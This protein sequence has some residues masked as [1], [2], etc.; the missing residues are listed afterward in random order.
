MEVVMALPLRVLIVEDNERDAALLLRELKRGGYDPVSERVETS[1]TMNAE[2]ERRT[3]DLVVSDFAMPQFSANAALEE[4][5]KS[6][7]DLPF[8]IV[9]G[10]V[11]EETAVEAMRAGAHDFMPKG[12]FTRLLPA[13]AR[14]LR[15]AELRAKHRVIEQ[16]LRQ[17]QKMEAIGQLTGGI[18]HDFNNLLAVIVGNL[19]LL[20]EIDGVNAARAELIDAALNSALRGAELTKRLLAFA[21]QQPLSAQV[22]DLNDCLPDMIAILQRTIGESIQIKTGLATDLWLARVDPAQLE[23]ALLNLAIN[24]R[25]AMPD[26]G[27]LLIETANTPLDADYAASHA[28][29]T[30]GDYVSLAVMD[31]GTG[32]PPDI[33]ERVIEPFFTT[34]EHGKG[35]GLGLSM[36]YGFAKQSGGHLSINS[37]IGVGTTMSLYFPR[38]TPDGISA[39]VKSASPTAPCGNERILVVEDNASVRNAAV[40]ILRSLGYDVEHAESARAALASLE[41]KSFDVLFTDVVMPEMNGVALA[42]EV[43]QCYPELAILFTSGFSSKLSPAELQK[44]GSNFVAKPY[45]K[46]D[47]A[48]AVRAAL[49]KFVSATK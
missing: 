25:D 17:A 21:R 38:G 8:I 30:P 20:C 23:N 44:L 36:I 2:L 19:D 29:V 9:S 49:E 41:Q 12:Q 13:I 22:I 6:G 18:A 40:G 5:R 15:E 35:T 42:A 37:E 32:I 7:L 43:R 47:L 4:V 1:A 27:T 48:I 3:W 34:K 31:T 28:E 24:A 10:T 11:G 33:I 39:L 16:Q 45:R 46:A 14:E 26:G